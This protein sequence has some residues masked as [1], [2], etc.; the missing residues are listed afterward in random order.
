MLDAMQKYNDP[1]YEAFQDRN[2]PGVIENFMDTQ[3]IKA[4][5]TKPEENF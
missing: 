1:A 5:N 3:R 2:E 4:K